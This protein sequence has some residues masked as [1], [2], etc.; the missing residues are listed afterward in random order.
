LVGLDG[1]A[2][3]FIGIHDK[4]AV[5]NHRFTDRLASR[6]QGAHRGV[7]IRGQVHGIAVTAEER[8]VGVAG[9]RAVAEMTLPVQDVGETVGLGRDRQVQTASGLELGVKVEDGD[10][11]P[12]GRDGT[13]GLTCDQVHHAEVHGNG[14]DSARGIFLIMR[15]RVFIP[16]RK[17]D[18]K[19]DAVQ[20]A[21]SLVKMFF[22]HL[23]VHHPGSGGHPL[24]IA[25]VEHAGMPVGIAVAEAS[26]QKVGD[27][28]EP[29]VGVFGRSLGL[30]WPVL[31][32]PHLVQ[33]QEWIE[34]PQA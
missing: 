17:I 5:T 33:K 3:F 34:L 22:R 30:A 14:R 11:R 6:D 4:G 1:F 24:H 25:G 26:R 28:F 20:F 2:D 29:P 23:G 32:G 16:P 10:V 8:Q 15:R 31:A 7:G 9:R 27:G 21:S 18:P 13:Q 19:L 12:D